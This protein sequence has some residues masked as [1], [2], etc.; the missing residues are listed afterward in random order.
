M[1]KIK[2]IFL[3]LL[4]LLSLDFIFSYLFF[5]KMEFWKYDKLINYF[6]RIPSKIYHHDIMANIDVLEPWGFEMKKRLI[7]N[8]LGFRDFS[9]KKVKKIPEKKR[10][11]LIGDSAIEGAGYDYEF[12]LGGLLQNKLHK[13]HEILNSAVG[14]YSPSIYYKKIDHFI[15]LGYKFDKAIIFLDPSDII[16]ELFIEWDKNENI[17]INIDDVKKITVS[18]FLVNNFLTFRSA[19][20]VS[21]ATENI[22]N[23]LKLRYKASKKYKKNFFKTSNE[24]VFFYRMTHVDRS[25]W[26]FDKNIFKNYKDGLKKSEK[27]LN[28]LTNLLRNNNIE[29]DFVLYPHPSQIVYKD[30]FHRPYWENWA[31]INNIN[32]ISLYEDFDGENKREITLKTFI[33]GDLH[34]NKKGTKI[35]FNSLIKKIDF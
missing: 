32:L 1:K 34:W 20:R 16:D 23:F 17:K 29:I 21:D 26:T 3:I 30:L 15:N 5:K 22:K 31:K 14:S 11:L 19:L 2:N 7:T 24:D 4:I 18:D 27:Y 8:S 12:T 13:T 10:I 25:A 28:K 9:N 6:W 33:F 35:V